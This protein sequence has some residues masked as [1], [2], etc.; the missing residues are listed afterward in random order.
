L[1]LPIRGIDEYSISCIIVILPGRYRTFLMLLLLISA[2]ATAQEQA[3]RVFRTDSLRAVS[4]LNQG[5]EQFNRQNPDSA[6]W[7]FDSSLEIAIHNDYPLI[8][9]ENYYYEAKI[10]DL[11]SEWKLKLKYYLKSASIFAEYEKTG[12]EAEIY[13]IIGKDYFESAV[14][15]KAFEY[16]IMEYDLYPDDQR[17][18]LTQAALTAALSA[19]L[20]HQYRNSVKWYEISDSISHIAC[21]TT[22]MIESLYGLVGTYM[23][24][25]S[26]EKSR[27]YL[28]EL[29]ILQQNTNNY[30]GVAHVYNS[31]GLLDFELAN[32]NRA[33]NNY[34]RA[35]DYFNLAGTGAVTAYSNIAIC[36][37]N[38][39]DSELAEQYF[40]EALEE[41]KRTNNLTERARLEHIIAVLKFRIGDLYHAD[42]YCFASIESAKASGNLEILKDG[43]FTY[44]EIQESGNDFVKALDYYE[45]YL[46]LRDS[47]LL[48]QRL[49]EQESERIRSEMDSY[50]QQLRLSLADEQMKDLALRNLRIE[51]EKKENDLRLMESEKELERSE[52]VRITQSAALEKEKYTT[53]LKEREIRD[54]EQER[55]I[56]R[57]EIIRKENEEK[58]LLRKNQLLESQARQQELEIEKE[59]EAR[60]R[61]RTMAIS[62]CVI[63]ILILISFISARNKNRILTAQK[64]EIEQKNLD[65]EEKNLAITDSIEYASRI[66]NAVLPLPGFISEWGVESFI[67][68]R[69]KDIVSGDFYWGFKNENRLYF[70]AADCTGHGVP[71]AFMSMLGIAYLN[72]IVNT[73][74]IR[75]AAQILNLL[76][77]EVIV[78]LRQRGVAGET[79]DG[80]DMALCI[81]D[82]DSNLLHYAGANNP[83]YLVRDGQ[84]ER[85][86][87]DKMP[88]GI[89]ITSDKPFTN[90][91]ISPRDGD[92]IYLFSDGYADQFGGEYGKKFKYKAFRELLLSVNSRSMDEQ[93]AIIEEEFDKW[94]GDIE[95][96]DDVLIIGIKFKFQA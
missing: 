79:Q 81:Y 55:E 88:I 26:V 20:G 7:F 6:I 41:A 9:A 25:G 42:Y 37:Q 87:A 62:L 63:V 31:L 19:Y 65:I 11:L 23:E 90:Y 83:L 21:D 44:S 56:Q 72:E 66:Q 78:S 77:E 46:T 74:T 50:E 61:A 49:E 14:Y 93:K 57:L 34:Q 17:E 76:R 15:G 82:T 67:M 16:A 69:P 38:R 95:Q 53:T 47:L 28:T 92:I 86:G 75:D 60:K 59:Q 24:V 91:E 94:M 22:A 89:H 51:N 32:Y 4:L 84:L 36:Y 10:M 73:K 40:E 45:K 8:E 3:E 33:I 18:S 39:G 71:G 30:D 64:V 52:R 70:A 43:Y 5:I 58:N 80:M 54:L 27:D 85:I 48:E 96:V 68:F 13:L 29:L 12:R 1:E 35:V 2:M